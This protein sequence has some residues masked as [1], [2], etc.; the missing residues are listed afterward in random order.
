MNCCSILR[1]L[2]FFHLSLLKAFGLEIK[3]D[4]RRL[5]LKK[6]RRRKLLHKTLVA[7]S[8]GSL[9]EWPKVHPS[10]FS[11]QRD[12]RLFSSSGQLL[13]IV[14]EPFCKMIPEI[15]FG[16]FSKFGCIVQGYCS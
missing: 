11:K 6:S 10:K 3:E 9:Y 5:S 13:Q 12:S 15:H 16:E 7:W 1:F 4:S 8:L 14:L 2:Q